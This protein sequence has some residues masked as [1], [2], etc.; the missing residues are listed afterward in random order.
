MWIPDD[1]ISQN[2][3]WWVDYYLNMLRGVGMSSDATIHVHLS[4][5][6]TREEDYRG[7]PF[8][9]NGQPCNF[10]EKV[11]D[12][13][14]Q[15]YRFVKTIFTRDHSYENMYEGFTLDSMWEWAQWQKQDTAVLYLH[16]KGI[17]SMTPEVK[18]WVDAITDTLVYGYHD[19]VKWFQLDKYNVVRTVEERVKDEPIVSGN[20]FWTTSSYIKSLVKPSKLE[21][22]LEAYGGNER[23][24]YERWIL[25]G[26]H[27]TKTVRWFTSDPYQSYVG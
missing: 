16:S 9:K 7:V 15:R 22:P 27:R 14:Q 5:P 18:A 24:K 19:C 3:P 21:V 1:P 4:M 17:R 13:I 11:L 23:Y 10:E 6:C 25:S 20:M 8:T 26:N 2:W 12:Y